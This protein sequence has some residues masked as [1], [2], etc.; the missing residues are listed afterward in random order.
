MRPIRW[1]V[2]LAAGPPAILIR[3]Y[4]ACANIHPAPPEMF[5]ELLV[6]RQRFLS[7]GRGGLRREA[8]P[9]C[10]FDLDP[11][12]GVNVP[13][14]L[15][16]R[17]AAAARRAGYRVDIQDHG[18]PPRAAPS[19]EFVG[20]IDNARLDLAGS[21]AGN[22]RG[23]IEVRSAQDKL[24][25]VELVA[26]VFTLRPIA[27]VTKSRREARTICW[28]LGRT[29]AEPVECC[30]RG[31]VRPDARIRVGT[32]NNLDLTVA[33]VVVFVDAT[34]I[35]HK[36]VPGRLM[37]L[38]RTRIYGLLGD[39]FAPSRRERLLIEAYAGPV[40]GRLGPPGERSGDVRAAFASWPGR[41]RPDEPL[42][43]IWK[44]RSIWHNPD[45][46][47]AIARLAE[48][49]AGGDLATLWTYGLF[50]DGEDDLGHGEKQRVV[51]LVE[52]LEHGR[53]LG[54]LLPG[55]RVLG[56]NEACLADSN[57]HE[58]AGPIPAGQKKYPDRVIM[59]LAF[60]HGLG[61]LETDVIIRADGTPWALDLALAS[62]RTPAIA[63]QPV[64]LVDLDD[65]QD[66]TARDATWARR[67]DYRDRGW[68]VEKAPAWV[69]VR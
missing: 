38:R 63:E 26:R 55:W 13:A 36:D 17:L 37:I 14:G 68:L 31:S 46:N 49:L 29:L 66:R 9:Q 56:A 50:L 61:S 65:D 19:P 44:R 3:D 54:R 51:V 11:D 24:S 20:L 23:V 35:L 64:L 47:A 22:R 69:G 42:G 39:H 4:G 15:V 28:H 32:I 58:L 5:E 8:Q 67:R 48:A 21:L 7:D 60:A 6:D 33:G 43:L 12:G 30:I 2:D 45:R 27:I 41:N 40:I 10:L 57:E 25:M 16:P 53:E 1:S 62:G 59:T 52:S 34:Q 18:E